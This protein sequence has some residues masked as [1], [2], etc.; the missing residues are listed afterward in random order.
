M[1]PEEEEIRRRLQEE[2]TAL[3]AKA[4]KQLTRPSRSRE[5]ALILLSQARAQ[6]RNS[7]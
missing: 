1:S 5:R 7:D 3:L 4:G 2:I 6:L